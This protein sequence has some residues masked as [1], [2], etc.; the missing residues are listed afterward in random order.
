MIPIK[1]SKPSNLKYIDDLDVSSDSKLEACLLKSPYNY[2]TENGTMTARDLLNSDVPKTN[3]F[4]LRTSMEDVVNS[5]R[6][7]M[8][9]IDVYNYKDPELRNK[10][11]SLEKDMKK[12]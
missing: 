11:L 4:S 10:M 6:T 2:D 8:T 3:Q 9:D 1:Q 7:S 12:L 5:N